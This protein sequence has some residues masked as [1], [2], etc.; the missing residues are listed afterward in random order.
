MSELRPVK[1]HQFI[2]LFEQSRQPGADIDTLEQ[3]AYDIQAGFDED[4]YNYFINEAP[5]YIRY[6]NHD[7]PAI[8]GED[9]WIT[10]IGSKLNEAYTRLATQE[11]VNSAGDAKQRLEEHRKHMG[12]L[13][14]DPK[15]YESFNIDDAY[16]A[17]GKL[18]TASRKTSGYG[19]IKQN[20]DWYKYTKPNPK[21]YDISKVGRHKGLTIQRQSGFTS[22]SLGDQSKL[23]QNLVLDLK[24]DVKH[25]KDAM[26]LKGA[27]RYAAARQHHSAELKDLNEDGVNEVVVY[28]ELWGKDADGNTVLKEKIP[29]LINGWGFKRQNPLKAHYQEYIQDKYGFGKAR[30]TAMG[31]L[32]EDD[33]DRSFAKWN[34]AIYDDAAQGIYGDYVT[35]DMIGDKVEKRKLSAK[36][37]F[38][39]K[40]SAARQEL[41]YS[42]DT[43]ARKDFN[44]KN[45]YVKL[46]ADAYFYF[47]TGPLLASAQFTNEDLNSDDPKI[48]KSIRA[49][50]ASR[51]FKKQ[52]L[53]VAQTLTG[54]QIGEWIANNATW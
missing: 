21:I 42:M 45:P 52:A 54:E 31:G 8:K 29:V 44:Q 20:D 4:D 12:N 25:I 49:T 7:D 41:V 43:D 16:D 10:P 51:E 38:D 34:R 46:Q 6:L 48:Q 3:Q 50:K 35:K 28:K 13:N 1:V 2:D 5:V 39:K 47:I 33:P 22:S 24:K 14:L 23:L 32:T 17:E 18:K 19:K 40:F 37:L 26:T 15:G 9:G 27:E 30:R 53:I 36:R 11:L